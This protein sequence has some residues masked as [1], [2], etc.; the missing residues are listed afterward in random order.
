[1]A[2]E[3][4][5]I[6]VIRTKLQRPHPA[7]GTIARPRLFAL[8]AEQHPLT[9]VVAPAGFGKTTL[10]SSWLETTTVPYGWLTLDEGDSDPA[11]F[12]TYLLAALQ[13]PA[14]HA[15][16]EILAMIDA[17]A[18]IPTNLLAR[19]LINDL[20]GIEQP[21]VLVLDDYHLLQGEEVHA[22]VRELLLHPPRALHLVLAARQ[23]PPLPIAGLRARGLATEVRADA[24][25]FTT[26]ETAEFLRRALD[27]PVSDATAAALTARAEGWIAGLRLAAI[28]LRGRQDPA[29]A[30][31]RGD[32]EDRQITD[33]LAGELLQQQPPAL[34]AFLVKTSILDRLCGPL[35]TAVLGIGEDAAAGDNS[36]SAKIRR[37]SCQRGI[38]C[39]RRWIGHFQQ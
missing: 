26:G 20:D 33:Y 1:M 22:I 35:C 30:A 38:R 17:R 16:R 5:K 36:R 31:S 11:V 18:P 39:R 9:L 14:P 37:A 15:G 10:V 3:F 34:Q 19:A 28:S 23:E 24:L 25:R 29:A 8:L 21:F 27:V 32:A 12:L 2:P 6:P 4:G 7:A 13:A